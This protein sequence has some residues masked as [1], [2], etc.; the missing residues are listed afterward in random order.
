MGLDGRTYTRLRMDGCVSPC[1]KFCYG[2]VAG[3]GCRG[4]SP[5]TCQG[6]CGCSGSRAA[7]TNQRTGCVDRL[8]NY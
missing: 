2:S 5:P 3:P 1:L 4:S 7:S 8:E 6:T